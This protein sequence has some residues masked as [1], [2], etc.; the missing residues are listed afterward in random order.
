VSDEHDS[1]ALRAD[2]AGAMGVIRAIRGQK[3][4]AK[5]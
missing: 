1:L 2:P 5:P 3:T 4:L